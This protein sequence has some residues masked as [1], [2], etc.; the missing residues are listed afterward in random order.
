[1]ALIARGSS[2]KELRINDRIK[3]P[4]VRLIAEDGAQLGVVAVEEALKRAREV[5]LDLVEV[6]PQLEPPVCRLMDYGKFRYEQK[7][8]KGQSAQ[9]HHHV[10]KLKELRLYPRT[11]QHDVE[12][13]LR[14]ARRFLERGDKVLVTMI[15]RG[16]EM[17]HIDLGRKVLEEFAV[18]LGDIAKVE[19]MPKLDSKRMGMVLVHHK[20]EQKAH[21]PNP[22]VAG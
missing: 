4:Q 17:T 10:S 6:A 5:S 3:A 22:P 14:Q 15:F 7:R 16:R 20:H 1:M 19:Q 8:K 11:Q 2:T 21:E 12:V 9:K 18:K 13:R